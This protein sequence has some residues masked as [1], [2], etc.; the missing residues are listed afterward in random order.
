MS[1]NGEFNL[2]VNKT[3]YAKNGTPIYFSPYAHKKK[4]F[5]NL[6]TEPRKFHL[7]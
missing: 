4:N 7:K 3:N 2:I 5:G 1:V 6:N